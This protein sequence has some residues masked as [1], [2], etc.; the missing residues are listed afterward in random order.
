[1]ATPQP[2][3]E[4]FWQRNKVF[5][6]G[7]VSALAM[8]LQQ[9]LAEQPEGYNYRVFITAGL[10]AVG[11]YI[12]NAW[13]GKGVTIA[14][15]LSIAG[16]AIATVLSTGHFTWAQF[17]FSVIT[18]FLALVSA[19][20]KPATYEHNAAIVEAKEIPPVNQIPDIP[21]NAKLP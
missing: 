11:S 3:G 10:I 9:I 8:T 14:G 1:M 17:G 20:P 18:G 21:D 2:T 7:L 6:S 5:I 16:T 19:P 13:R 15:F 12:G 4:N